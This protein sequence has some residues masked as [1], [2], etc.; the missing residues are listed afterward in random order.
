MSLAI[1]FGSLKVDGLGMMTLSYM[2]NMQHARSGVNGCMGLF[3]ILRGQFGFEYGPHT[4]VAFCGGVN[5]GSWLLVGL[6]VVEGRMSR[7]VS[8]RSA[9]TI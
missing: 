3:A 9:V 2:M 5:F 1:S 8:R 7:T 6:F 4:S